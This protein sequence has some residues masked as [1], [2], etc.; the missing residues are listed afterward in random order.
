MPSAWSSCQPIRRVHGVPGQPTR[1]AHG[2]PVSRPVKCME[3]PANRPAECMEFPPTDRP[4]AWS[5]RQPTRQ[6]HGVPT[7]RL[8]KYQWDSKSGHVWGWRR[9]SGRSS[10][11]LLPLKPRASRPTGWRTGLERRLQPARAALR[12]A[13]VVTPRGTSGAFQAFRHQD[14]QPDAPCGPAGRVPAE[15]GVPSRWRHHGCWPMPSA[16]SSRQPTRQV[17]G[18]PGQPTRRVHGVLANRLAECMEFPVSRRAKRMEFPPAG[19]S[20]A[21][22]S[23]PTDPPSCMEFPATRNLGSSGPPTRNSTRS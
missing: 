11:G 23:P 3:F 12:T 9:S 15:A 14:T 10:A 18:V 21:W 6:V 7:N 1:Q 22:S 13:H 2:V 19:P 4:S 5:S 16:W 17:H 20:S 8:A